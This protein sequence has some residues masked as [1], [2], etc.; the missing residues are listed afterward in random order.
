MESKTKD[1]SQ[2]DPPQSIPFWENSR[3]KL[4]VILSMFGI[5]FIITYPS[6]Y[7][8]LGIILFP[9]G[10]FYWYANWKNPSNVPGTFWLGWLLYISLSGVI[11]ANKRKKI[12]Q[13]L[14]IILALFLIFNI[15]G[16]QVQLSH[17]Q[18]PG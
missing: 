3:V 17:W 2:P 15:H 4:G 14:F 7:G 8:V 6:L 5:S 12:V 11:V 16:C 18:G 13:I 10:L 9:K 1:Q